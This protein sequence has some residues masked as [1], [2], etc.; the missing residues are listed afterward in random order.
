ME[1]EKEGEFLKSNDC[2]AI[3]N[4]EDSSESIDIGILI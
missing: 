1:K 2:S 3:K 4:I